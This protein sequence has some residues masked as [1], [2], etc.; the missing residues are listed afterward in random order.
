MS[1]HK[2]WWQH[3][4]QGEEVKIPVMGYTVP[5]PANTFIEMLYD[6]V[7][8]ENGGKFI[9][10]YEGFHED[11]ELCTELGLHFMSWVVDLLSGEYGEEDPE[12]KAEVTNHLENWLMQLKGEEK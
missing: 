6:S 12:W 2:Y 7:G 1:D 3:M 10:A 8:H 9:K 11:S 4:D 5:V